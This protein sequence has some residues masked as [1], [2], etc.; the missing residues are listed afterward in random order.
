VPY[1]LQLSQ[2]TCSMQEW[3]TTTWTSLWKVSQ[4]PTIWK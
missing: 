1:T 3:N 2:F 4:S